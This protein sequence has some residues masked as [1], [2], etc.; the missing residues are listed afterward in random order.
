MNNCFHCSLPVP[1]G[2]AWQVTIDAVVQSMCCPGCA[3]VAQS[4]VDNGFSDYYRTREGYAATAI[5]DGLIPP[6]LTLY[7]TGVIA[8]IDVGSDSAEAI[9]LIEDIRCAAC[10]WLIERRLARLPGVQAVAMNAATERLQVSWNHSHC[11][12]SDI[13]IALREIGYTAMPYD[14]VRHGAQLERAR[15]TL[16]RQLFIAGLSMMQVMMYVLP[17]YLASD[18]SM[19]AEMASLMRWASLLLTLPAL[20]YSARPFFRGAWIN[21]KSR[22]PG[23][24]VP[25]ALG[26]GAAFA[27]S[28][29]ATLRG[30][31][32]VY[33]DSITMFIFLLLC[34][35]YLELSARRKAASALNRLQSALPA[36]AWFMP[37]YPD[38]R[39]LV[40]MAAG[41]LREGDVILVRPGEA[42]AADGLVLE[43]DSAV[44]LSLLTGESRPL[45]KCVGATLPGGAVN[46]TQ[47]LVV[48]IT[49]AAR[50][51]TLS[52][53]VKL[54]ERAGQGK[55]QLAQWADQVAA[56]FVGILLLFALAVFFYWQWADAARAW[57]IA[58]AVLVVSCPCALSLATP[59][60]LAAATDRLVRRGILIVQPHVLETLHRATHV[61]F[62]KTGTLTAG[63]PVLRHVALLATASRDWCV[64]LAAAM[65]KSSAHPLAAALVAAAQDIPGPALQV[66]DVRQV[67]GCG[68]EAIFEG[69]TV[70]LGTATF[71]AELAGASDDA[72]SPDATAVYLGNH[73]GWLV[74]FDLAD[75]VRSDAREVVAHFQRAGKTVILLSGDRQ[76]V[77]QQVA[78]GLGI[79]TALGD[80][81][82]GQKLAYVQA[83]QRDGAIVAMVGDG[84]NDAAVLSG[85]DVSF[86]MGGGTALAQLHADCVLLSGHLSALCEVDTTAAQTL[87][88]IGQNLGWATLY[89]VVAIP[90]AALGWLSPWMTGIG[91]SVSSAVV[92]LNALRLRRVRPFSGKNS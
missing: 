40:L 28:V 1:A 35:R 78:S 20:L 80:V 91:M 37:G 43:G 50:D 63:K 92:V 10:V 2:S 85:V 51:S 39:A 86:A 68:L 81:L 49:Q 79:G 45:R 3:A 75:G 70:R 17:G 76:A 7:D 82:P 46:A 9:F 12:P 77:A 61:I 83:L 33:F 55:P 57:P 73:G 42:I 36:S 52:I 6:G 30:G 22:Q 38:D 58:I 41:Q 67:A 66:S 18:G 87:A 48:R 31:G 11:K 14:P 34:S 65:E 8:G 72:G 71:V 64:Q 74:R 5:H 15:K 88:V 90:A 27:G 53:L 47:P 89:N 60:A 21:L 4:I 62:D 16:F 29:V 59:T 26:I 23:M 56:W 32:E 69:R 44:D 25:V 13:L 54:I 24:D 84:I 19:D